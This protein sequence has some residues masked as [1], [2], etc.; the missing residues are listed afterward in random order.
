MLDL[1]TDTVAAS[2]TVVDD[3]LARWRTGFEEVF[4]LVASR[5]AQVES[6]H[7]ARLYLLGLLSGAERKNSWT[8]AEQA[9]DLSRTGWE[10]LL[11]FYRWDADAV[12][13][14]LRGYM[15]NQLGDPAGVVV[16]DETGF[17][18]EGRPLGRGATTVF[19]HCRA[20][21]ELPA[22]GVL[23]LHLSPGQSTDRSRAVPAQDLDRG[24]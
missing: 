24:P 2:W 1:E 3:R 6:R 4:G 11:N 5:F 19:G 22:G 21:R 13:D 16:T 12:R 8:I 9:G 15:L 20:D 7:R 23:D 17:L 10:R 18:E 14:D